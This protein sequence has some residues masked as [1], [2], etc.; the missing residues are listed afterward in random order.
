MN[1]KPHY[2]A[3]NLSAYYKH[4]RD[5]M[6]NRGLEP[7]QLTDRQL[8][9][10]QY[11]EIDSILRKKVF[12]GNRN[13]QKE[14]KQLNAL[15]K[16]L[17]AIGYI[18]QLV[19][20]T[21]ETI[22]QAIYWADVWKDLVPNWI[23]SLPKN[24]RLSSH[25]YGKFKNTYKRA[26]YIDSSTLASQRKQRTF[27]PFEIYQT[28]SILNRKLDGPKIFPSLHDDLHIQDLSQVQLSYPRPSSDSSEQI[29]PFWNMSIFDWSDLIYPMSTKVD[30]S[31][32]SEINVAEEGLFGLGFLSD[33]ILSPSAY[34][35]VV[36]NSR[37]IS[38]QDYRIEVY[39]QPQGANDFNRLLGCGFD[40]T[41]WHKRTVWE[42]WDGPDFWD[43]GNTN[44]SY[45]VRNFDDTQL[46]QECYEIV[47]PPSE[48]ITE[49]YKSF[50]ASFIVSPL[51]MPVFIGPC[52]LRIHE[53][54]LYTL[55]SVPWEH[56]DYAS[57]FLFDMSGLLFPL[58]WTLYKV[59]PLLR[60][61]SQLFRE[62]KI[63]EA[64][65][66]EDLGGL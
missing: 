32:I 27:L 60:R 3:P 38:Y 62:K 54:I 13:F 43:L 22:L 20:P 58:E 11:H 37:F 53:N 59:K 1:I 2:T 23:G 66:I 14:I 10:H 33:A 47:T 21:D 65:P 18:P 46:I 42:L 29:E 40:D 25:K 45:T 48:T 17:N 39:C 16:E 6:K 9:A 26:S 50:W 44:E 55:G 8:K 36:A 5:E 61:P 35:E 64:V 52:K 41:R 34:Y 19:P 24:S 49:C 12:K 28:G 51:D 31:F 57:T 30:L 7:P 56:A 4:L 15:S 63:Y